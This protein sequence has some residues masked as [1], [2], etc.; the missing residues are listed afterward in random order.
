[1]VHIVIGVYNF[2]HGIDQLD[3]ELCYCVTWRRLASEYERARCYT[4][5]WIAFQPVV[6]RDDVQ[7]VEV[8]TFVF[9]NALDLDVEQRNRINLHSG[10]LFGQLSQSAP[11]RELD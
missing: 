9:M 8:L 2:R 4:H 11:I 6:Q 5:P 7:D 1:M 10:A 3:D